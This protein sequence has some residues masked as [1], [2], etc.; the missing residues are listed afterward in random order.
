MTDRLDLIFQSSHRL[1]E[2]AMASLTAADVE[3][4][5]SIASGDEPSLY[6]AHA[7]DALARVAIP[8]VVPVLAE[9]VG[10][11]DEDAAIRATA[12]MQL[13]RTG[14]PEAEDVLL[15]NLSTA[16]DLVVVLRLLSALAR[17]GTVF[18]LSELDQ[19][20]RDRQPAV[21]QLAAFSRSVI[22]YR[23]GLTGYEV[24]APAAEDLL[25]LDREHAAQIMVGRASAHEI[26]A[27]LADLRH[28]DFGVALSNSVGLR[29]ECGLTRLF[30]TVSDDFVRRGLDGILRRPM[31]PAL[32]AQRAPSDGSYSIRM[33]LLAGPDGDGKFHVALHRTDG[34]PVMFGG[35]VADDEGARFE[36]RSVRGRGSFAAV[37]RG[38]LHGSEIVFTEAASSRRLTG[39]SAPEPLI[40]N[41]ESSQP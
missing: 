32:V 30:M 22:A 31:V 8:D 12:A 11:T 15:R 6:R 1:T 33:I 24:P 27:T 7:M 37:V 34:Y 28:D 25:E 3:R 17:I 21:S 9:I 26:R 29:I 14:S 18:S 4:L 36:L 41:D 23:A 5:R 19:V 10:N 13:A 35:G 16:T 39:Q 20:V 40:V 2:E 38:R